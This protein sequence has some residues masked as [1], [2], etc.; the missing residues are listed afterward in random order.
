MHLHP[1]AP[2]P[3]YLLSW[4]GQAVSTRARCSASALSQDANT[5]STIREVSG[6]SVLQAPSASNSPLPGCPP[7]QGRLHPLEAGPS[8]RS[9]NRNVPVPELMHVTLFS[10][11]AGSE[12]LQ[13]LSS[14]TVS[15]TGAPSCRYRDRTYMHQL[16]VAM[17]GTPVHLGDPLPVVNQRFSPS[18][19]RYILLLLPPRSLLP[20]APALLPPSSRCPASMGSG[21]ISAAAGVS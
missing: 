8:N 6:S 18:S 16:Q 14:P 1:Y 12:D 19:G 21:W 2:Q 7:Q 20:P 10:V 4:H 15:S 13:D 3:A 5:E 11:A 9:S 17:K